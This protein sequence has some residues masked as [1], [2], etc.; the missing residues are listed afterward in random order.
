MLLETAEELTQLALGVAAMYLAL[1]LVLRLQQSPWSPHVERRRAAVMCLLALL[2]AATMVA[3]DTLKGQ[4]GPIDTAVL[5]WI[6]AHVPAVLTPWFEAVTFTA[7]S[8]VLAPLT[9]A[10]ALGLLAGRQR[11]GALLMA[12]SVVCAALL[13][14]GMKMLIGRERPALWD[15]QWYW[16]SSFPSGHTL[17]MAAFAT[18]AALVA[19]HLW[20]VARVPLLLLALAWTLLVGLSRLV[21]GVH[22]PTDVMVAASL[23]MSIPLGFGLALEARKLLWERARTGARGNSIDGDR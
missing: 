6:R 20:P 3:E 18:A 8:S 22:W 19:G 10:A 16:G 14:Y 17:V 15:V 4:S 7:S 5:W 12:G 21:L 11:A 13:V 2:V 9:V 23:G 1:R